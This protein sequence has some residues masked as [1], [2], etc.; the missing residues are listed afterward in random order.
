MKTIQVGLLGCG[1]VGSGVAKLLL[2]QYD[3]IQKRL[4]ARICLKSIADID[5]NRDRGFSI[6][7]KLFTTNARSVVDD[8]DIDIII[9]AIGGTGIARDLILR[10]IENGKQVITANKA[11]LASQG[12][13]LFRA[14]EARHVDLGFEAS[15]GGCM[16]VIKTLRESLVGN[17]IA[18]MCGILNGTCNYILSKITDEHCSF[19]AAL[20]EAQKNGYAEADPTLDIEG[21]DTAHKLGII[22]TL[23]YG[24]DVNLNDIYVE[25][26][27]RISP[28][29]IEFADQF[30]YR[31]KLLA[32]SKCR[33]NAI[34]ARVHPTMISRDNLLSSVNG[35]LNA[36]TITGDAAGD[37]LLYGRGAGMMPTASAIVSDLIDISR[38]ILTGS[39]GRI[40]ILSFQPET[41][42]FMPVL[43]IEEL[44]SHYYF[45]FA[46]MD[47]PGVLSKISGILGN[48]RISLKS[49]HQKGRKSNSSVPLV[50]FTHLAKERD[51]RLALSEIVNL[52]VV[53]DTP[54]VIRIEDANGGI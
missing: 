13:Q 18:S 54:M 53:C 45:R 6:D 47:Q 49:V 52:D 11:L 7:S 26:I 22:S 17:T 25:G 41:I 2:H 44:I 15:V 14:A 40:P 51:V 33:N 8:S 37:I 36:L 31:I 5:V 23:A 16:P 39:V 19:E 21:M 42:Q 3:I 29:D 10:A 20:N 46:A 4:G 30:D 43:P 28:M 35:S 48:H 9:E 24:S 38:N 27:S 32:I 50:M 12:S 1:T 34:E